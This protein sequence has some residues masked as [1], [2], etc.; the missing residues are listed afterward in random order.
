VSE[1]LERRLAEARER[2]RELRRVLSKDTMDAW[3]AALQDELQAE[4]ELAA[5]RDEMLEAL[6]RGIESRLVKGTMRGILDSLTGS[7]IEQPY[8]TGQ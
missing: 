3:R 2:V 1:L 5:A 6:A 8:R 7:L 4:R